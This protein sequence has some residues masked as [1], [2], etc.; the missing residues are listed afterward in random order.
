MSRSGF[1]AAA[2]TVAILLPA[3]S[4]GAA[5]SPRTPTPAPS[6]VTRGNASLAG[7]AR[8]APLRASPLQQGEDG[9]ILITNDTVR[10]LREGGSVTA[11]SGPGAPTGSPTTTP[12]HPAAR[13]AYW[14]RCVD[15]QRR[16]IAAAADE[17]AK[18]D[19]RVRALEDAALAGGRG[20]VK[21]WAKVDEAKRRRLVIARHL[22]R[23]REALG[24]VIR[25]ARREGAEPGWFR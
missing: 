14:R 5:D 9:G 21:R 15:A 23:E 7:Y 1:C 11:V 13:R 12:S 2:W 4:Q 8:H 17:L 16:R 6:P 24:A 20:A 18:A 22:R 3:A 25:A 19:A 10:E